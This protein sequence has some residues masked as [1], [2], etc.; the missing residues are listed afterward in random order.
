MSKHYIILFVFLVVLVGAVLGLHNYGLVLA[1]LL[2]YPVI[3]FF[4]VY[5]FRLNYFFTAQHRINPAKNEVVLTFD[6]GPQSPHTENI[7]TILKEKKVFALFFLI[8]KNAEMNSEMVRKIQ[9]DG[10][11]IGYHS[12]SHSK[13]FPTFSTK[14]VSK[15]ILQ[16]AKAVVRIIN[17]ES[18][19]FRPPFG[20]TNPNIA[21]AIKNN[22]F[23]PIGWSLRSYDTMIDSKEKLVDRVLSRVKAGDIIL[24]HDW[25]IHT[26]EALPEIIDGIRAKGLNFTTQ[27]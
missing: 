5:I 6:D 9:Q 18:R 22:N 21:R 1:L 26:A 27:L 13:W 3:L 14:R 16:G 24:L 4:G 2:F 15:D 20:L 7:L 17:S 10:H 25:G 23:V 8:G 11:T 12:Y 19:L